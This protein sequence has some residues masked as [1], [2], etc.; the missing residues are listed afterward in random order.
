MIDLFKSEHLQRQFDSDGYATIPVLDADQIAAL[1]RHYTDTVGERLGSASYPG[2][3]IT[4]TDETDPARRATVVRELNALVGAA[5]AAHLQPSQTLL[6]AYLVKPGS[7]PHTAPHQDAG[8]IDHD[9]RD[10]Q[11]SA[12]VWIPL[13]DVEIDSGALGFIKSSHR[14]SNRVIGGPAGAVRALTHGHEALLYRYLTFVPLKAGEAVVF[15]TRCI[16][17]ALPNNSPAPRVAV[18]VRVA[19]RGVELFQYFLKPGTTNRLLKLRVTEAC[20]IQ[21]RI[22]DLHRL[23][24]EGAI[25]EPSEVVG[26]VQDDFT[27]LTPE[28]ID[29][30]CRRHGAIDNGRSMSAPGATKKS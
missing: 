15:D 7:A 21:H 8:M 4:L 23:Y 9:R 18:A 3:Y 19:P 28:E 13:Q 1:T 12:T 22:Q 25:P 20:L 11:F 5:L 14:F 24:R 6:G 10:D 17:G 27:P 30:L 16:H 26:E 2:L 29:S